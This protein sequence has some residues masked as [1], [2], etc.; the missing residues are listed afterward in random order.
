MDNLTCL[1]GSTYDRFPKLLKEERPA[2][3]Q[4]QTAPAQGYTYSPNRTTYLLGVLG[5]EVGVDAVVA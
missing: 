3:G 2:T 5:A 4:G 1:Y